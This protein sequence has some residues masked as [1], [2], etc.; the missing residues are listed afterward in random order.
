[1]AG[2]DDL[3]GRYCGHGGQPQPDGG[4]DALDGYIGRYLPRMVLAAPAPI[5]L[6]AW[7]AT[8]TGSRPGS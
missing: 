7:I 2:Q 4:L 5:V 1:V 8:S 3:G 6:V